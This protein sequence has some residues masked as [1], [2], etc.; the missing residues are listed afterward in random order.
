MSKTLY[1]WFMKWYVTFCEAIRFISGS[2]ACVLTQPWLRTAAGPVCDWRRFRLIA[3]Y[4]SERD[5]APNLGR[6]GKQ[7]KAVRSVFVHVLGVLNV[8]V[9]FGADFIGDKKQQQQKTKRINISYQKD[10]G[11]IFN[12]WVFKNNNLTSMYVD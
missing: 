1:V 11:S 6:I 10:E 5:T 12:L 7:N 8:S 3:D 2:P 4:S 9:P